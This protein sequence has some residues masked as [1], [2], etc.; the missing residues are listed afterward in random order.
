MGDRNIG[1]L[2]IPALK[3]RMGDWNY[4]IGFLRF[5][6]VVKRVDIAEEI[7]VADSLKELLQRG[8]KNRA[9]EIA[10]YL[11]NQPQRFF[12]SLVV[13]TYGGS[14]CWY[15]VGI[16]PSPKLNMPL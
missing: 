8:L 12:N 10:S 13:G 5:I 16:Q 4:Y 9:P 14:P 11:S 6:D 2:V 3:A 1:Q 15:E 7:H